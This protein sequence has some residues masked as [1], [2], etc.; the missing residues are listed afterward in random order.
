MHWYMCINSIKSWSVPQKCQYSSNLFSS[1]FYYNIS[2]LT[3]WLQTSS[4]LLVSQIVITY[5]F[6]SSLSHEFCSLLLKIFSPWWFPSILWHN[7]CIFA[8]IM[9][10]RERFVFL[11]SFWYITGLQNEKKN[12]SPNLTLYSTFF[13]QS[14]KGSTWLT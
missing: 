10:V 9:S 12:K 5:F 2:L 6:T 11:M 7:K 14:T 8:V 4:F 13:I 1:G 3:Q